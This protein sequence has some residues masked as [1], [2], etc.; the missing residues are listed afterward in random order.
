MIQTITQEW[1]I[2]KNYIFDVALKDA[3]INLDWNDFE[4]MAYNHKVS[5]AV[6]CDEP[7][8]IG[9]QLS[10]VLEEV[11]KNKTGKLAGIIVVMYFKPDKEMMLNELNAI[12]ECFGNLADEEVNIVWGIQS[13]EKITNERSITLFAFEEL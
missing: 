11:E 7:L 1:E 4:S 8:S 10:K 9:L 13:S 2:T 5:M 6:L 12:H 3:L